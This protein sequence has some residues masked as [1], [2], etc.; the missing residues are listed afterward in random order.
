[1]SQQRRIWRRNYLVLCGIA[2]HLGWAFLLLISAEPLHTT[3]MAATPFRHN[4]YVGA[5]IYAFAAGCAVV[6]FI[7]DWIDASWLGLYCCLPQQFL[8][9]YSAGSASLCVLRGMYAD[10]VPRPWE[11]ILAD[12]LWV[13]LSMLLHSASLVDWYWFSRRD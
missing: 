7:W 4:Q 5:A 3:P 1:M 8:L 13:I 10:G 2:V 12:Q 9:M 11:F 6:P